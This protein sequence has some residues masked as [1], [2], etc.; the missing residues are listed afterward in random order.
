MTKL[1]VSFKMALE[2]Y[3]NYLKK[4]RLYNN[5]N[6]FFYENNIE[7]MYNWK[8]SNF[9]SNLNWYYKIKKKNKATVKTIHLEKMNKWIYDDKKG[10][11]KHNSGEFFCI[12]G[13]RIIN[14]DREVKN[15]DQ[16]FLK[17]INYKGGIIGL[18]RSNINGVPHYLIDAKYEPGNYNEIQLSP[19]L[20]A[21]YSNLNRI[22]RGEKNKVV[23]KYFSKNFFTVRK[24][25]VTEDGGRL[26][27]KRNMHWIIQY[28]GKIN[29]PG[30]TYKWLTLWDLQQFIKKGSLVGP[31]L[32]SILS[33][34]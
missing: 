30:K 3:I 29:T 26:F 10:V 13:K 16:P 34:I 4:N 22:H 1:N 14:S 8:K 23:K 24:F 32:R 28:N 31:H 18:V 25:W 21:T 6:L 12:E 11:I 15:W 9:K 20:Q 17:Q 33:L 5:K 7:K 2:K 19:S 27:K